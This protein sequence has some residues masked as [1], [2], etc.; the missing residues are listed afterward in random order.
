MLYLL[1]NYYTILIYI[2]TVM[3]VTIIN[4]LMACLIMQIYIT[5]TKELPECLMSA[6]FLI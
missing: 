1:H 5:I 6:C 3:Y 4:T 2:H